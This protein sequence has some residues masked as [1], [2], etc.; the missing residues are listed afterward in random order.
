MVMEMLKDFFVIFI[1]LFF[2]HLH[3]FCPV[4]A[5]L[6]LFRLVLKSSASKGDDGDVPRGVSS[7][8][9]WCPEWELILVVLLM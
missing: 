9:R 7:V 5:L 2:F 8:K 4:K 1:F 3:N 6:V